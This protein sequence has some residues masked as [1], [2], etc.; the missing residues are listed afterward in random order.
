[1]DDA[2]TGF[3]TSPER[4][5]P[6]DGVALCLSGGGFRAMLFH[7]GPIIRLN[8]L[9]MLPTLTCVSSVSGGSITAAVLGMNWT[10]LTFDSEHR[11]TNLAE[12]LIDPI[13]AFAGVNVDVPAILAG[14]LLPGRTIADGVS[15]SYKKHLFGKLT[16]QDLPDDS[17]GPRFVIDA[18]SV[19]T[20]KLF[21]FSRPYQG[22]YTVGLWRNP[23]TRLAEAVTASSAFPPVMSPHVMKPSGTFD[24]TTAGVNAHGGFLKKH[25]LADGGVYDNLGLQP[26][27]AAAHTVLVSDAGG[28]LR[29][30]AK[31]PHDWVRHGMRVTDL[32]DDQ[33]RA[34]RK[35]ELIKS[36]D[37]GELA[38]TF[39]GINSSIAAYH[40]AD[41]LTFARTDPAYPGNVKTRLTTLEPQVRKDLIRWGYVIAD[42]AVRTHLKPGTPP[43]AAADIPFA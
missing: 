12:L 42:T 27:L 16:L 40:L 1:M 5:P 28:A 30:D 36:Y 18:T 15:S 2:S 26:A 8:Q 35:I 21:R 22:E 6:T 7:L 10:K 24:P 43:P 32:I 20:G 19:Q 38:G 25:S 33:V 37:S 41:A 34:R 9:G 14:L 11:A 4:K 3:E 17:A 13:F 23:T 29:A 31:Q 39:W